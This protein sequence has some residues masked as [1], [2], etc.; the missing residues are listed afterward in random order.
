MRKPS[1]VGYYCIERKFESFLIET[2]VVPMGLDN[3]EAAGSDEKDAS[4]LTSKAQTSSLASLAV[5][6]AQ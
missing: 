5:Q 2:G 1:H 4:L 6:Y 3:L